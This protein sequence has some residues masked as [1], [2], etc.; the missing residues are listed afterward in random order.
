MK[1]LLKRIVI[2]L[3]F[4]IV[5]CLVFNY[6]ITKKQE[7]IE[8]NDSVIKEEQ[9]E[10]EKQTISQTDE[11]ESYSD[12]KARCTT[13]LN[14]RKSPSTDSEVIEILPKGTILNVISKI[15]NGWYKVELNEKIGYV[16][17]DY[18]KFL[19]DE[20]KMEI[21]ELEVYSNTFAKTNT[22]LNI[23]ERANKES[24]ILTNVKNESIL[25]VLSKMQNGWYKVEGNAIYGYVSGEYITLLSNEEY[26]L[27]SSDTNNMLE[28]NENIIATYTSTSTY[29]QNSRYNMHLAADYMN[30]TSVA[31][32]ETYSHL[33]VVHPKGEENKYVESTIFVNNGQTAQASGGGICQTSSTTYA[34]IVSAKEKGI[35]T[36]LNVTAQAPHS[37]KVN[38]VPRK[39]EA[40]VNSGTQDFCFRNCNNYSIKIVTSYNYNTLT[41]TIYKI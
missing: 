41:V 10:E 13:S 15:R 31:P 17:G 34:A 30:G 6:F 1:E 38:Y 32:G 25:K 22:S 23:R 21:T 37:G 35:N 28:P 2:V 18:I 20:E 11:I 39:Y 16:S 36:G 27:Y 40:T 4:L 19:S 9:Q 3:L 5:I 12:S 24:S 14:F 8:R 26:S 7:S 29:N 33:N